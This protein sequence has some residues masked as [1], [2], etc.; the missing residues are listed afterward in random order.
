MSSRPGRTGWVIGGVDD[1][2]PRVCRLG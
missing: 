1:M 2:A